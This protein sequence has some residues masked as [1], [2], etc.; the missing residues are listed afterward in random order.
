MAGIGF[1]EIIL[2]TKEAAKRLEG[3][4]YS[5]WRKSKTLGVIIKW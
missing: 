4:G 3:L 5:I 1:T 2:N